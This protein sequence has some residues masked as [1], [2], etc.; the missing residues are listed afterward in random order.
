MENSINFFGCSL[1]TYKANLHTHSTNS[2][3][4][5]TP[6]ELIDLYKKADYDV[7]CFSDH[8][9]TND[10]SSYDSKG[11]TLLSGIEMHPMGPRD[12]KWHILAIGVPHGFTYNEAGTGQEAIDLALQ[13]QAAVFCAHPYWCGLTS[14]E[15]ATLDGICGIEVYNSSCRKIGR[16][17]N[18]PIWDELLD[19]GKRYTALAVDDTHGEM[20][21]FRGFTVIAAKDNTPQ[22]L[23]SA[24][25]QG[26]FYASQGPLF[27][28]ITVEDNILKAEFTPVTTAIVMRRRCGGNCFAVPDMEGPGSGSKEVTH[29]ELDL[30]QFRDNYARIQLC[31]AQGR[32]AWS[33]PIFI[34]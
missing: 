16:E 34:D 8:H 29:L 9:K 17:Y 11:M 22:S 14:G 4:K 18:M 31:D 30:S 7:L 32:M 12:I 13:K 6:E 10:V 1:N 23:V 25:K 26:S 27:R 28:S 2:D 5:Y 33:N 3:G 21:L 15:V 19:A 24:L 20:H